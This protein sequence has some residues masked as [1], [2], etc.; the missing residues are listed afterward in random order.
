MIYARAFTSTK[1]E[2]E[3][4][5]SREDSM[6]REGESFLEEVRKAH[7]GKRAKVPN[8]ED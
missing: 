8:F 5:A 3:P 7:M 4:V 1:I 6:E 2:S